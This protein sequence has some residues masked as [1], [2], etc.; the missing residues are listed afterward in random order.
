MKG[1]LDRLNDG[2]FVTGV[3]ISLQRLGGRSMPWV[4]AVAGPCCHLKVAGPQRRLKL[5]YG[6]KA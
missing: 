2:D 3:V 1:P 6:F 5:A 4:V